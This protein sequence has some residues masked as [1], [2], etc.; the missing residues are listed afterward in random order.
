MS[1]SAIIWGFAGVIAAACFARGLNMRA[2]SPLAQLI[3]YTIG[4]FFLSGASL[5]W[6]SLEDRIMYQHRIVVGTLGA[7]LGGLAMLSLAEWIRPADAKAQMQ[8]P[9]PA[10]A[11]SSGPNT[12]A[13]QTD[14]T[15]I[16]IEGNS[17]GGAAA[18]IRSNGTPNN[19]STG[20]D[21]NVTGAPGQSITGLHVIQSRPGTGL[22]VIQSGPGTGLKVTA[23]DERKP[24]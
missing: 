16:T 9:A 19:P 13:K 20:G 17:Q 24:D 14:I 12:G 18:K 3:W 22:S 21:I 2:T 5:L 11:P 6:I 7:I 10:P 23:G 15:G 8:M 1:N 4:V